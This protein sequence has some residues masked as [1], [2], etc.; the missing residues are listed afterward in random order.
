MSLG[1]IA[2]GSDGA[3]WY[4]TMFN[5]DFGRVT[6]SGIFTGFGLAAAVKT[7]QGG[8]TSGPD[9]ALWFAANPGVGRVTTNGVI[10]ALATSVVGVRGIATGPD[11]AL[12]FGE[13]NKIGRITTSGAITEFPLPT[14]PDL[15]PWDVAAGRTVRCGSRNESA[16]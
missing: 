9:G 8:I 11:G 14:T 7:G 15:V 13:S 12:W 10:T 4:Q 3:L 5:T 2:A 1:G 16:R 6:T